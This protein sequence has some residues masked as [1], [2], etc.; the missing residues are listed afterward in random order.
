[1][2]LTGTRGIGLPND[3]RRAIGFWMANKART[4][5]P[6]RVFV[7]YEALWQLDPTH[8]QDVPAAIGIFNENRTKIE[9]AASKKFDAEGHDEGTYNG[10]PILIVRSQ[11]IP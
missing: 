3:R 11:D 7:T 4:I 5:E 10:Q 1:M 6:V 8:P 2:P 9:A